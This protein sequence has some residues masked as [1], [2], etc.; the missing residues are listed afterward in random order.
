MGFEIEVRSSGKRISSE[1][2]LCVIRDRCI[3]REYA[4]QFVTDGIRIGSAR[5][6][7]EVPRSKFGGEGTSLGAFGG[8][9][10]NFRFEI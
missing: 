2:M 6:G 3:M 4:R 10:R 7:S 1:A 8:I 9:L 5:D